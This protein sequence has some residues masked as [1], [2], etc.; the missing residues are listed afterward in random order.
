[1]IPIFKFNQSSFLPP[2]FFCDIFFYT[3]QNPNPKIY[4]CDNPYYG[5]VDTGNFKPCIYPI[6]HTPK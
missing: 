5:D 3:K 2:T 6:V 4:P 1:M